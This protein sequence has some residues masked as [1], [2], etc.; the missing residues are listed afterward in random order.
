MKKCRR[1]LIGDLNLFINKLEKSHCR[2]NFDC[3]NTALNEFIQ[4][5]ASQVVKRHE[6]VIYVAHNDN[7]VLGY[8]TLSNCHLRQQYDPVLFRKQSPHAMIPCVLL[9]RLAVDKTCQGKGLGG[10]LLLHAMTTVKQLAQTIGVAF[11]LVEAKDQTARAFYEG[12]GFI[13]LS[14]NPLRLCYPVSKINC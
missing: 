9:G 5:R 3:G 6:A 1:S 12:Y 2:K 8:Y 4:K 7:Q 13:R 10:D 14:S 11:V